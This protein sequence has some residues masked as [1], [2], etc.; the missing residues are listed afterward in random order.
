MKAGRS[1]YHSNVNEVAEIINNETNDAQSV[2]TEPTPTVPT[3]AVPTST[4]PTSTAPTSTTQQVYITTDTTQVIILFKK[5][6][7]A[8]R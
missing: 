6:D 2:V 5:M 4:I 8:R 7:R 1:Q 3:S